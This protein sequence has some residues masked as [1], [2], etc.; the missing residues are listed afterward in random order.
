M[1][2]Y[3]LTSTGILLLIVH[4]VNGDLC[5]PSATPRAKPLTEA[6]DTHKDKNAPFVDKELP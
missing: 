3:L 4:L 1:L 2:F 6:L 5:V